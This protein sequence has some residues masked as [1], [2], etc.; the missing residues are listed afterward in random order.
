MVPWILYQDDTFDKYY[1]RK[2][3]S[4]A[5]AIATIIT[6]LAVT[7]ALLVPEFYSIPI[8]SIPIYSSVA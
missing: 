4:W 8:Y 2:V 3:F 7:A 5:W 6:Q 1:S